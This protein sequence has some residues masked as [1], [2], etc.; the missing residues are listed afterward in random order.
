MIHLTR[1]LYY[2]DQYLRQFNARVLQWDE[3]DGHPAVVLDR[4]AFYPGG[5]GQP[6][7]RG[8]INGVPVLDVRVRERGGGVLHLLESPVKSRDVIGKVDW[9]RRFDHMQ[10]HTGQHI[11][12]AAFWELFQAETVGFH[13]GTEETTIDLDR[14]SLSEDQVAE[15]ERLA[16]RIV[17][18]DREVTAR[19]L[20]PGE[21]DLLPLRKAPKVDG[22]IRVV[23]IDGFD[24][25]PCG[26]T[27]VRRTGEVGMIK[28]TGLDRR[29][30]ALRVSFLCGWRAFDEFTHLQRVVAGVAG[31]LTTGPDDIL[32]VVKKLRSEAKALGKL[33]QNM[34]RQ[35]TAEVAKRL[36]EEALPVGGRYA[37][38]T[39]RL[40][41][42]TTDLAFL[43]RSLSEQENVVAVLGWVGNGKSHVILSRGKDVPLDMSSVLR[44]VME[45][46]GGRGGGR[47][48]MAQG[49]FP[50]EGSLDAAMMRAKEMIIAE[51]NRK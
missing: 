36:V 38:V 1:R 24:I 49:G 26:G 4:T 16:N 22:P 44:Q 3:A 34:K 7:D 43:S 41:P 50:G 25:N 21:E 31:Y 12:S 5:G 10:Q 39:S 20:K 28:V 23:E 11:L 2:D 19:F 29:S 8:T 51:V 48:D 18:E 46:F 17:M 14:K 15:A 37:L 30:D 40:D 33:I 13:M 42:D 35:L 27:H 32:D 9:A 45:E 6:S 47:P